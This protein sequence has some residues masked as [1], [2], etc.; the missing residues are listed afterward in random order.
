VPVSPVAGFTGT[1]TSG[2]VPLTVQFTDTSTNSP[3]S[4]SWDFGDGNTST[5]QNP[6]NTYSTAGNYTVSLTATNTAGSNTATQ[7]GYITVSDIPLASFYGSETSGTAPFTVEFT[8]TSTNSPTSW[9]WDFGDGNTSTA[10]NPANTYSTAGNY[11]VSLTATNTAG[12]NTATQT[13]YITVSDVPLASFYASETSG[14]APFTVEFTD[15]STN[16][17]TSWSWDF[18]DDETSAEQNPSHTYTNPGTYSVSLTAEN[19]AGINQSIQ[20]DYLTVSTAPVAEVTMTTT[21]TPTQEPTFP[22]LSFSG[23]PTSGTAP[24]TV[25]FTVSSSGAPTSWSWD[26]GDGGTSTERDPTYT[27]VIPG[28]YTVILTAN[29]PEGSNPVTK[30]SYITVNRGSG[31]ANSPLT[32]LAPLGAIGIMG[33]VS[34]IMSG[35]KRH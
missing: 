6:A 14:T 2:S 17:P 27:Y 4:W 18:G 30:S 24:L 19:S 21:A 13:G 28:T 33:I 16:S 31:S 34:L 23:T 1:P 7:T 12:S 20:S 9:S 32:P 10:Q 29:Y 15:T 25:Q 22:T 35:R 5:A 8:D 26:F 11:T 3:T